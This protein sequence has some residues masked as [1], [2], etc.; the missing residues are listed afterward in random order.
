[1]PRRSAWVS[2]V[3]PASNTCVP[4]SGIPGAS[5]STSTVTGLRDILSGTPE[6]VEED[7]RRSERDDADE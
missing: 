5:S 6:V 1:M 4:W 3:S 7:L 2:E